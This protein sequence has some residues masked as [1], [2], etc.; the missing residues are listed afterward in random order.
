MY[1]KSTIQTLSCTFSY[2][3]PSHEPLDERTLLEPLRY[4]AVPVAITL[5]IYG[6]LSLLLANLPSPDQP[7]RYRRTNVHEASEQNGSDVATAVECYNFEANSF[8][9]YTSC[10]LRGSCNEELE[11][12]MS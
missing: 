9:D 10:Q 11:T 2:L 8:G 1:M 12:Y 5:A 6:S 3:P 7:Q 4:I